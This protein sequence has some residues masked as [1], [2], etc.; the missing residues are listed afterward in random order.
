MY[1]QQTKCT[2]NTT[3]FIGHVSQTL[4][5][6]Y[7]NLTTIVGQ[8]VPHYTCKCSTIII[9]IINNCTGLVS[10]ITCKYLD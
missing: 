5:T 4:H 3:M 1:L 6:H 9:V 2:N 10:K 7:Y 8:L